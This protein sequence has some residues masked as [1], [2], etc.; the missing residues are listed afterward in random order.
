MSKIEI[1]I[2]DKK[3]E[4]KFTKVLMFLVDILDMK[5]RIKISVKEADTDEILQKI[6]YQIPYISLEEQAEWEKILENSN[7]EID[8]GHSQ[9]IEI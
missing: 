3:D 1:L 2:K 8:E 6:F 5:D 9:E 7:L 4:I